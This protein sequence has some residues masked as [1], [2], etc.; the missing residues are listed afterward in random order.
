M[1]FA[2]LKAILKKAAARTIAELWDVIAKALDQFTPTE[3]RNFFVAAGY[4]RV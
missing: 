1:A 2:K 3:C 4:E